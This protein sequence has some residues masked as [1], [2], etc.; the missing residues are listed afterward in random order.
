MNGGIIVGWAMKSRIK[1]AWVAQLVKRPPLA[2]VMSQGPGTESCIRLPAW[3]GV[4]SPSTLPPVHVLSLS[5]KSI[6]QSIFKKKKS[7]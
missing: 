1:G 4:S 2:Q 3:Q 7:R 6:D 5:L